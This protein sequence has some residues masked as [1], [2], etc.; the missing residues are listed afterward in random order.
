M[1]LESVLDA[2]ARI[3]SPEDENC[4]RNPRYTCIM[5]RAAKN[6]IGGWEWCTSRLQTWSKRC[7]QRFLTT[8]KPLFRNHNII[9]SRRYRVPCIHTHAHTNV[10]KCN[11]KCRK[12][13]VSDFHSSSVCFISRWYAS[14]NCFYSQ[15]EAT[16]DRRLDPT[17]AIYVM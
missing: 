1:Q 11:K 14:V 10:Y 6:I 2:C 9:S 17:T 15:S 13:A 8:P 5:P 16:Q 4:F 7:L 12:P 3:R